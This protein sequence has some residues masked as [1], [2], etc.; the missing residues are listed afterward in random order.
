MDVFNG[1]APLIP[2]WGY[3]TSNLL[4][5]TPWIFFRSTST[6]KA[7]LSV[8]VFV[9][10]NQKGLAPLIPKGGSNTSF[11]APGYALDLFSFYFDFES[12]AFSLCRTKK[13]PPYR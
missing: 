3:N 4:Q 8:F 12:F 6:L 9:F 7:L 2:K 11:K 10:V 5:A 1:L 13:A